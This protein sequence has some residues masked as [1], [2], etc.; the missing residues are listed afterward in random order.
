MIPPQEWERRRVPRFDVA[1]SV[2]LTLLDCNREVI[3]TC[4][5]VSAGGMFCYVGEPLE[6][7]R[8]LKF[9]ARLPAN[10]M[11][12]QPV[13]LRGRGRVVRTEG[14]DNGNTHGLGIAFQAAEV[15]PLGESERGEPS[16][17]AGEP[18]GNPATKS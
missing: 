3:G 18:K 4:K 1:V 11:L 15:E 17:S 16:C 6:S 8:E 5:N 14:D 9:A 12:A 10:T 2:T 13:R 7:A